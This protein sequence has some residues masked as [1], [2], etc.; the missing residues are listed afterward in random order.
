[1]T[2]LTVPRRFGRLPGWLRG[3]AAIGARESDPAELQL[4]KAVL[5][6]SSTLMT[7]LTPIWIVTYAVLGL[8]VPAA[9]PFV[10]L[11]V[12]LA[13]IYTFARTRRY[14]LFRRAQLWMTLVLPFALQWSLGGFA[15][16]SAVCLWASPPRSTRR[17]R[18][19]RHTFRA[20]W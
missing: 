3:L 7:S 5:V 9:I 12:S 10:Y 14:V 11:V 15:A 20:A 8:W 19:A 4:H 18:P 13:S 17:L 16:S 2:D 1:M 6:L